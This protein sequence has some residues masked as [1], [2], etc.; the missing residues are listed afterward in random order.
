MNLE[1]LMTESTTRDSLEVAFT[2]NAVELTSDELQVQLIF[3]K[4]T[5]VSPKIKQD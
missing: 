3:E 2:W 5:S 4:V 1:V